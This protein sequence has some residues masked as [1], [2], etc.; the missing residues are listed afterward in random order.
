MYPDFLAYRQ[1]NNRLFIIELK[2]EQ[3]KKSADT[4]YKDNLFKKLEKTYKS[5]YDRG[6]MKINSPS[7][8]LRMMF[9][10]TWEQDLGGLVK[11]NRLGI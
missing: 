8:V 6:E 10:D 7:A 2:G 3:F 1:D 5:S 11:P 4:D 9:E